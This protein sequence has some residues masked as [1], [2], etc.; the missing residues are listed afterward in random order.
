M[1]WWLHGRRGLGDGGNAELDARLSEAWAAAAAAVGKTLDLQASKEAFLADSGLWHEGTAD[2]PASAVL[3]RETARRRR[4]RLVLGSVAG[5]AAALVAGAAALVTVAAPGASPHDATSPGHKSTGGTLITAAYVV[6]R[7]DSAL[8]AAGSGGVAQITV[9]T[10]GTTSAREWSYGDQWRSI[11][12]SASGQPID[13]V[14]FS[15]SSSAYTLVN[16]QKHAWTR[17]AGLGRPGAPVSLAPGSRNCKVV[18]PALA[19]MFR[20]GLPGIEISGGSPPATVASAL[21][22]AV[23]CGT[24]TMAGRQRVDGTEAIELTSRP[25]SLTPETIWV[26]PDTYLPVRVTAS[27]AS[28]QR[29]ADINWLRPTAQNLANLTVPVPAGFRQVPLSQAIGPIIQQIP[30]TPPTPK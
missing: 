9:T 25:G 10:D 13:D 14:G 30:G 28:L 16:Y 24:L 2:L 22:A 6:Q 12:Y 20:P 1:R 8:N 5:V 11:T 29:T 17:Q 4:R 18:L 23:S 7:V 21:R 19:W 26:S 27:V 3:T 15:I